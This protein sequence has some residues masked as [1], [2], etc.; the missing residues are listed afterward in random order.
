[1]LVQLVIAAMTTAPCRSVNVWPLYST[2]TPCSCC[3][4]RALRRRPSAPATSS[5]AAETCVA[6]SASPRRRACRASRGRR[7]SASR[8]IAFAFD[9]GTRSC[10]RFGPARLGSTVPRSSSIVSVNTGSG[11]VVGAEESLR[12]RVRLDELRRDARRR[13]LRRRYLSVSLVDGEEAHRRAVLRRH[14]GDRRAV[15]ERQRA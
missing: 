12:L 11:V 6:A 13:P 1:M 9:S 7:R 2:V 4:C 10:G 15:G 14:V 5:G 8:Y 3:D